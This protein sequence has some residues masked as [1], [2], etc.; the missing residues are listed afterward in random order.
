MTGALERAQRFH[1]A[2]QRDVPHFGATRY[3]LIAN[4][5]VATSARAVLTEDG[6]GWQTRF[7]DDV[8]L[9]QNPVLRAI[10]MDPG[11]GHATA[12]SQKWLSP[13]E[14]ERLGPSLLEVEGTHRRIILEEPTHR[15]LLEILTSDPANGN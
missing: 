5:G 9:R 15:R 4:M 7:G 14:L 1:R 8:E 12:D 11:D 3:H 2:L 10:L 6:G 13:Q